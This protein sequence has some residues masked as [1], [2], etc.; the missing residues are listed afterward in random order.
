MSN[1]FDK[2][3]VPQSDKQDVV[4]SIIKAGLS[5]IPVASELFSL[6]FTAPLE[7]R[8]NEFFEDVVQNLQKLSQSVEEFQLESILSSESFQT[9]VLNAFREAVFNHEEE[10]R[11]A[12]RN[13]ILNS[14][15]TD[16]PD[17]AHKKMFVQWAGE[18]TAWHIK[19]LD[20]FQQALLPRLKLGDPEWVM[21]GSEMAKL[22][23]LIVGKFPE[24]KGQHNLYV[25]IINDLYAKGLIAT[26]IFSPKM[27]TRIEHSPK[28]T[29]LGQAFLKFIAT[30]SELIEGD[31][32]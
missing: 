23:N 9:V 22:D 24:L 6:I 28:V 17:D 31:K 11:L 7:K 8:R 26:L 21:V 4:H 27:M 2:L 14:A 32:S 12:L 18:M 30:P 13:A 16:S 10:N 5:A 25:Q 29:P 20:Y 1:N 15:L 19:L 3:E